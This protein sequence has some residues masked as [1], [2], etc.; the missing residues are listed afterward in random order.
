MAAKT[1]KKS[2]PRKKNPMSDMMSIT[3]TA[4]EGIVSVGFVGAIGSTMSS[5]VKK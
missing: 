2:G 3:K 1:K 4:T 5:L